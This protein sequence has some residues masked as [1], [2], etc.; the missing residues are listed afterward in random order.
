MIGKLMLGALFAV[1]LTASAQAAMTVMPLSAGSVVTNV[2]E[3]CGAGFWRGPQGHCHP[4]AA[5]RAC[6]RGYHLGP[7]GQKCW[8]N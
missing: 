2:A 8:P 6:P 4:F 7:E 1:G 3:G 5:G